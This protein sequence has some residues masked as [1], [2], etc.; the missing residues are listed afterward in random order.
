MFER[1]CDALIIGTEIP[2][3]IT[4]A[5]LARRGLSVQVVDASPQTNQ[6]HPDPFCISHLHS[7]LLRSI[8]GRLNV[9][10]NEIQSLASHNRP[11]QFITPKK[12]I[13]FYSNPTDFY[14]ELEREFKDDFQN[15]KDFYEN[16]A[17]IKHRVNFNNLYEQLF[18]SSFKEKREFKKF[19]KEHALNQKIS[20]QNHSW[21]ENDWIKYFFKA[22]IQLLT[23]SFLDDPFLFQAAEL[24]NPSD[25][26]ILSIRGGHHFL[27]D[28]FLNRIKSH[29]GHYR[30]D[31][32][33]E[34]MIIEDG[35]F[36]GIKVSDSE[37]P[38]LS[39]YIV[40]NTDLKKL[41]EYL[42]PLFRFRKLKKEIKKIEPYAHWFTC[43]FRIKTKWISESMQENL[44]MVSNPNEKLE[45]DNYLYIQLEKEEEEEDTTISVNYLLPKKQLEKNDQYFTLIHKRIQKKIMALIPF[46]VK[47][48]E[49]I[50]PLQETKQTDTLFPLEE[51]HFKLFRHYAMNN[52]VYE[53]QT[54]GFKDLFPL[55]FKTPAPNLFL[56]SQE[57]GQNLGSEGQF[58]LGLKVTDCI[59]NDVKEVK[60]NA[61]KGKRR[62]A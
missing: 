22:Q 33:I 23:H 49:Y 35:V 34:E 44:I 5:F 45:G 55:D 53:I 4:A 9:P 39:R 61:M 17:H 62:I 12:R 1:Y 20:H 51:D 24:L 13:D 21:K 6:D 58:M 36:T 46:S 11:I 26:E 32:H 47:G 59:W 42:P 41:T 30:H 43:Q 27:K 60:K 2:G 28:I 29:E 57:I 15:L 54:K 52:P 31:S 48:I 8:L 25:G 40:W 56:T 10:E 14:E 19:I 3:L 7:K 38:I 37:A 50:F 18:P 16:L